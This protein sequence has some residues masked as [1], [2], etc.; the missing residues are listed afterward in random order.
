MKIL[1]NISVLMFILVS[2]EG[3]DVTKTFVPDDA[4]EA[5]LIELGYDDV[6]DNF[7]LTSNINTVENLSI[8]S[9]LD[10]EGVEGEIGRIYNLTGIHGFTALKT[11]SCV[12]QTYIRAI[13]FSYNRALTDV[14][15]YDMD[16]LIFVNFSRNELLSNVE[17]DD[18]PRIDNLDFSNSNLLNRLWLTTLHQLTKLNIKNGNNRIITDS[19]ME[20]NWTRNLH[21]IEV[22]DAVWSTANWSLEA[23]GTTTVFLENCN[24]YLPS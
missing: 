18:C 3:L 13:D 22:D 2:C 14:Y 12:R 20:I 24:T 6:M 8:P 15:L 1:L 9:A 4:F 19:N 10:G 17:I 21:C 11:F 7:V 16:Y 5:Y 23:T